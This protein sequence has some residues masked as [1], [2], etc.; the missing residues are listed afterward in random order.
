LLI[1]VKLF[2]TLRTGRE[3]EQKLEITEEEGIPRILDALGIERGEVAL[4]LLNGRHV[5]IDHRLE[6]GD[7]L[8]LFPPVGG[9]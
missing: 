5:P 4:F 7:S 8:A 6:E 1:I 9:G 3:K 2:A